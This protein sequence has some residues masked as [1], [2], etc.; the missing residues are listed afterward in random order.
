MLNLSSLPFANQ[1]A[2]DVPE[3]SMAAICVNRLALGFI[4]NV[5]NHLDAAH[6]TNMA[7][8]L[9]SVKKIH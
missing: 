9:S 2:H 7:M 5:E 1:S 6:G 8:G 4:V 3:V